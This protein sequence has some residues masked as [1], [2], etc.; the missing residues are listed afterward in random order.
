MRIKQA[1]INL[2]WEG[3]KMTKRLYKS[4]HNKMVDGVYGGIAEYFNVDPTIIR[5]VGIITC[6]MGWGILAYIACAVIMPRDPG[7]VDT[8]YYQDGGNGNAN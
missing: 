7:V 8:T 4:N 5:L 3:F 1:H 6:F 2:K